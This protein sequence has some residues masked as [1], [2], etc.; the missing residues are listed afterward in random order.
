M[1]GW[2]SVSVPSRGVSSWRVFWWGSVFLI[3]IPII[4]LALA[5]G[6]FL[7]PESRDPHPAA[8]DFPGAVL[9]IGAIT[10]LVY[11]I[12]EAPVRG[13]TDGV[14]MAGFVGGAAL[15]AAFVYWE[16]RTDHPMLN[17][18]FFKNPRFSA[19]AG[20]IAIGFFALFGMIFGLTQY[21][22]FVQGYTALEAGLRMV[23]IALGMA[24]G[25]SMSHRPRR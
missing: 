13:W 8:L 9:S 19:G 5:A 20:A 23:P 18:D 24:S 17:T 15:A 2:V 12:I 6:F 4:A 14:V 1:P 11:S 10:F 21:L 3:N 22:Q 25:A 16:I 7:V